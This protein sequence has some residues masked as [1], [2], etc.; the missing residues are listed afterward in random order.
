MC[1]PLLLSRC[2]VVPVGSARY[3]GP[4]CT[5]R[6]WPRASGRLARLPFQRFPIPHPSP[7]PGWDLNYIQ[8]RQKHSHIRHQSDETQ[9]GECARRHSRNKELICD[10]SGCNLLKRGVVPL[11]NTCSLFQSLCDLISWLEVSKYTRSVLTLPPQR[12]KVVF[13]K[14]PKYWD[15]ES[16]HFDCNN[17]GRYADRSQPH[18][19]RVRLKSTRG[20][21]RWT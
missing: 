21:M 8:T 17:T 2:P 5:Q 4:G 7:S 11:H 19:N 9:F 14:G 6:G 3:R 15:C 12:T 20:K 13:I 18:L 10:A 16:H 1:T